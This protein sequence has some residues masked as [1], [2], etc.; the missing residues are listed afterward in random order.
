MDFYLAGRARGS[1]GETGAFALLF[2]DPKNLAVGGYGTQV[3]G[4]N[5]DFFPIATIYNRAQS[6]AQGYYQTAP[7]G[8]Y[9]TLI[10]T[11]T[12]YG[13]GTTSGHGYEWAKLAW[14]TQNWINSP[15]SYG[16]KVAAV[17]GIDAEVSWS[18]AFVTKIWYSGYENAFLQ[19]TTGA[20]TTLGTLRD[21]H[22]RSILG[23]TRLARLP[24]L[25]HAT[26]HGLK[27]MFATSHGLPHPHFPSHKSTLP[28]PPSEI[29]SA[30]TLFNGSG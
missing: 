28:T 24:P 3:P 27:T 21:V 20:S 26:T 10:I 13:N 25:V 14:D 18:N 2:G 4:G 11:T 22:S 15:P 30:Q 6:Y 5:N 19:A 12:N 8:A 7:A 23:L 9:M 29:A 16:S 1:A 17:A